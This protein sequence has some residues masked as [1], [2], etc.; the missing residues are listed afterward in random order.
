MDKDVYHFDTPQ[1]V[2]QYWQDLLKQEPEGMPYNDP[3]H[4][5]GKMVGTLIDNDNFIRDDEDESKD[6]Q[7]KYPDM[8]AVF[9][10][11]LGFDQAET[12]KGE[13]HAREWQEVKKHVAALEVVLKQEKAKASE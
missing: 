6:W 1:E 3:D 8:L 7:F 9:D 12:F 2:L 11:I 13:D 5:A 10:G 4:I